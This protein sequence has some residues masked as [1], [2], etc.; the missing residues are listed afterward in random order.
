V[1]LEAGRRLHERL[2]KLS[3]RIGADDQG[4]ILGAIHVRI[5]MATI[6]ELRTLQRENSEGNSGQVV[7]A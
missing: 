2:A 1:H 7:K 6:D 3:N 5:P 4:K